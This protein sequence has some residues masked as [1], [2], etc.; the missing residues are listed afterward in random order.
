MRYKASWVAGALGVLALAACSAEQS[1]T[2][3]A[4]DANPAPTPQD[5]GVARQAM[6]PAAPPA[7]SSPPSITPIQSQPGPE[8]R[9][10]DLL[11]ANVVG[12]VLNV[13]LTYRAAPADGPSGKR[14]HSSTSFNL[15][16]VSAVDDA[17]SQRLSVL[18]DNSGQ[19]MAAPLNANTADTVTIKGGREDVQAWLKFPAPSAG[20]KTVTINIPGAASFDAAPITR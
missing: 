18:K 5:S 16:E 14:F 7:T 20:A 13:T 1:N 4:Q 17:T 15:N 12:D 6:A 3:S 19:W 9:Y 2:R 10:V 8:G 11:R